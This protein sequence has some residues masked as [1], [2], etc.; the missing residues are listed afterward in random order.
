MSVEEIINEF[1]KLPV[2]EKVLLIELSIKKLR[3]QAIYSL[4]ASA[5]EELS[6][7]YRINKELT[8]FTQSYFE[9]SSDIN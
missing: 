6:D 1:D 8:V 2:E 5:A 9:N 4:L 3:N 7:E